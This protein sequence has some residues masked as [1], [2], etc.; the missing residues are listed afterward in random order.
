MNHF[1]FKVLIN[2]RAPEAGIRKDPE[3]SF[4]P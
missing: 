4:K 3:A 1:Y 2:Y